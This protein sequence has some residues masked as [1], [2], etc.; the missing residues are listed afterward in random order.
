[1]PGVLADIVASVRGELPGAKARTPA[2]ALERLA[3]DRTPRAGLFVAA[4]SRPGRINVLAECKRR[5]PSAGVLRDQYRPDRL[6]QAYERSG[7]VAVSVLTEPKFFGGALD[8]LSE[9]RQAVRL[10]V[11][12]K[13]FIVDAYQLIEARAAGADAVLLVAAALN[14]RELGT[15]LAE[16]RHLGLAALVEVHD[17]PDLRCAIEA[18]ATLIGVNNRNL[19]TLKVDLSTSAELV[20]LL[21]KGRVAVAESGIRSPGDLARLR[22]YGFD[23]F[24]IGEY[25]MTSPEPGEVLAELLRAA[26]AA[27]GRGRGDARC[28]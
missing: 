25:L 26:E 18:G 28:G 22:E 10:P 19:R 24:L 12:R 7:A 21:P 2:A 15:L 11:L 6:A 16:A 20:T 23:A 27:T 8:H 9:V 13:D 14:D 1:M 5:S 17:E 3:R 4:L